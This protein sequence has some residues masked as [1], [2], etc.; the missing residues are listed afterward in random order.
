MTPFTDEG[1]AKGRIRSP[2]RSG[3]TRAI[4][5]A[6]DHGRTRPLCD[7]S[8]QLEIVR[9]K[10]SIESD[11]KLNL[12]SVYS[13]VEIPALVHGQRHRLFEEH[14]FP[15]VNRFQRLFEMELM[16]SSNQHEIDCRVSKD[17][18]IGRRR[19]VCFEAFGVGF[20]PRT[21]GRLNSSQ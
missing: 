17:L 21:A 7:G 10:A 18:V 8:F 3:K 12:R 20:S 11:R 2:E 15:G 9:S 5:S 6:I 14:M 19:V 16:A 1:A 13:L 4:H